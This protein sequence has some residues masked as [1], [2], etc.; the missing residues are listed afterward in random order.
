MN[1]LDKLQDP[2]WAELEKYRRVFHATPDYVTFTKLETGA[3][4]DVNPAFEQMI[5]Y[6]RDE[7]IG[8][9][10]GDIQLWVNSEDRKAAVAAVKRDG[11]IT[12]T[13]RLRTRSGQQILV[14]ASLAIFDL[15]GEMAMVAVIR[16]VTERKREEDE[17]LQ[18]RTQL[19]K[20]VEQRTAELEKALQRVHELAVQD[21]LT[22][23]GNRRDLNN[24][25]QV[26]W[27]LFTRMERPACIAVLDLDGLKAV[28]DA[29]GHSVGDEVI[30]AF[31]KIVQQEMRVTDYVARYGGDEFVVL[32]RATPMETALPPLQRICKAVESHLWSDIAP[33]IALTTSIGV[34]AFRLNESVDET[35][36]RADKALYKAK[37]DGRNRI[38]VAGE[39]K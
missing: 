9:T 37:M 5:G 27:Q 33:N 36:N 13:T 31:A 26:E 21:E 30:K 38:V 1:E 20:L 10:T 29:L 16:D 15:H 28:N 35:F 3:I 11:K 6:T 24:Q 22:G 12:F 4:I 34:A 32:F 23:V 7:V 19:E 14:E 39:S 25:L 17:L 18:Y 2:E 8:R